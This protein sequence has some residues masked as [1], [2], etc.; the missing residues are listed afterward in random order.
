MFQWRLL[1]LL[2]LPRTKCCS[3]VVLGVASPGMEVYNVPDQGLA[4]TYLVIPRF[5][6]LNLLV[7][8]FWFLIRGEQTCTGFLLLVS[9]LIYWRG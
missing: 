1:F 9:F 8:C 4:D 2:E 3:F 6:L 5:M 7:L